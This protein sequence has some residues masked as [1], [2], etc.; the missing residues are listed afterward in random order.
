[1][2]VMNGG[3]M[4]TDSPVQLSGDSSSSPGISMGATSISN[5]PVNVLASPTSNLPSLLG[6]GPG[7]VTTIPATSQPTPPPL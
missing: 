6:N 3:L 7:P 2:E 5:A 4:E 1:M